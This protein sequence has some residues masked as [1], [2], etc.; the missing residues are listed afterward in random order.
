[1]LS[2]WTIGQYIGYVA[3]YCLVNEVKNIDKINILLII[4]FFCGFISFNP[5]SLIP[6]PIYINIIL[7]SISYS[8]LIQLFYDSMSC[9]FLFFSSLVLAQVSH[10]RD[11]NRGLHL[12]FFNLSIDYQEYR[13]KRPH[14]PRWRYRKTYKWIDNSSACFFLFLSSLSFL[15]Q[16]NRSRVPYLSLHS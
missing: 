8:A 14:E 16:I 4:L 9:F 5:N 1:M 13:S 7:F 15:H 12:S 10:R 11:H 3:I 6:E 2:F